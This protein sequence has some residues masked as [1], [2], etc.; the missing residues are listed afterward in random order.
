MKKEI[1]E[2]DIIE[3]LAIAKKNIKRHFIY[4][5]L[6]GSLLLIY[7]FTMTPMFIVSMDVMPSAKQNFSQSLPVSFISGV[8]SEKPKEMIIFDSI[9]GSNEMSSAVLNDPAIIEKLNGV[10]NLETSGSL[11]GKIKNAILYQGQVYQSS[12]R[13]LNA[14]ISNFV[15]TELKGNGVYKISTNSSNPTRDIEIL[16]VLVMKADQMAREKEINKARNKVNYLKK[17]IQSTPVNEYQLTLINLL[18]EEEKGLLIAEV[19][20]PYSFDIIQNIK[21]NPKPYSPNVIFLIFVGIFFGF[22]ISIIR[23]YITD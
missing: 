17:K 19:N 13:K 21:F 22:S 5:C 3:F 2:F 6:G 12:Q 10:I 4:S 23:D 9:I 1:S 18:A 20:T 7:S 15:K 16:Q 14:F 11:L 8:S